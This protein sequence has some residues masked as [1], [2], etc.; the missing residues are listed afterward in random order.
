M[1]EVS[2]QT[3]SSS[4]RKRSPGTCAHL[5]CI[6]GSTAARMR[7]A[8]AAARRQAQLIRACGSS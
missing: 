2:G 1:S 7:F 3:A 5:P 4:R 8:C 6:A